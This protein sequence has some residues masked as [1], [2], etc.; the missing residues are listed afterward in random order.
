MTTKAGATQ[1]TTTT[2]GTDEGLGARGGEGGADAGDGEVTLGTPAPDAGKDDKGADGKTGAGSKAPPAIEFKLPDGFSKE[3]PLLKDVTEAAAEL[4]LDAEKAQK[5][6][7]RQVKSRDAGQ[8][9]FR[10]SMAGELSDGIE[11]QVKEWQGALRTDKEFGGAKFA[12]NFELAK[13]GLEKFGTP[14]FKQFLFETGLGSHPEIVR[15]LYR[16]AK[17]TAEDSSSGTAGGTGPSTPVDP[18]QALGNALYPN[19]KKQG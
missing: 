5:L 13:Q 7:D 12:E 4:G 19:S 15:V 1:T 14:E 18:Y 10:D 17:A 9:A 6:F 8:T 16:A 11:A 2:S 3:D